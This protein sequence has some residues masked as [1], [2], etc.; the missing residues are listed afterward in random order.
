MDVPLLPAP[1][2][3][4]RNV[5]WSSDLG[6][7]LTHGSFSLFCVVKG[8][9]SLNLELTWRPYSSGQAIPTLE[10]LVRVSD[11]DQFLASAYSDTEEDKNSLTDLLNTSHRLTRP[12]SIENENQKG[13]EA[14]ISATAESDFSTI[15]PAS[16]DG[17]DSSVLLTRAERSQSRSLSRLH[18]ERDP[19]YT[20]RWDGSRCDTQLHI[21][22]EVIVG[23]LSEEGTNYTQLNSVD[24]GL[25]A[26]CHP[27]ISGSLGGEL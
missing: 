22:E 26:R 7:L 3:H 16:I 20:G 4:T 2:V 6:S 24:T 15:D 17:F 5:A 11:F 10:E 9:K 8:T 23:G 14:L 25:S 19:G 27:H 18:L 13:I 12:I 21:S 1:N